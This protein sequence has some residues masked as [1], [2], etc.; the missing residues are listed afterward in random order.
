MWA[1]RARLL[2]AFGSLAFWMF[3]IYTMVGI[4]SSLIFGTS[5]LIYMLR[6]FLLLLAL[7]NILAVVDVGWGAI[8]SFRAAVT[9]GGMAVVLYH[10]VQIDY[11][12][13]L[14]PH[15]RISLFLN[16][17][18]VALISMLTGLSFLDYSIQQWRSHRSPVIILVPTCLCGICA[19]VCV[20]TKSRTGAAAFLFGAVLSA[21]LYLGM[22]RLLIF[23]IIFGGG[24]VFAV[25]YFAPTANNGISDVYQFGS[26]DISTGT[27]RFPVWEHAF[28]KLILPSPIIGAGLGAEYSSKDVGNVHNAMLSMLVDTGIFGT[29]PVVLLLFVCARRS[30]VARRDPRLHFAIVVF[31]AALVES[32][33]ESVLFGVGN[34]GSLLFLL[35]LLTLADPRLTM[36]ISVVSPQMAPDGPSRVGVSQ[37]FARGADVETFAGS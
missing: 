11:A 33:A 20:A 1:S 37:S 21:S 7:A 28:S 36:M 14:N 3:F 25:Q 2:S 6:P 4:L 10:F 8:R 29:V 12:N 31:Y 9:T 24:A 19:V 32:G 23:A 17:N 18:S 16:A 5:E 27:G 35:A 22:G 13:I 30:I 15:Y 34:P 26:R